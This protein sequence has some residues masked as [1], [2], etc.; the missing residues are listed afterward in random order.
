[1]GKHVSYIIKFKG[2]SKTLLQYRFNKY[3]RVILTW[4]ECVQL[5][6]FRLGDSTDIYIAHVIIKTEVSNFTIVIIF[7]RGCVPEMFV[8]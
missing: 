3:A 1:M 5:T 7:V 8:T 2:V 6:H 4:V